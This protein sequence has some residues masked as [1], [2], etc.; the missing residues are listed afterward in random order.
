VRIEAER[1]TWETPMS[2]A[3][4]D[5]AIALRESMEGLGWEFA[6]ERSE[7]IFSRFAIIMPMPKIAYVFRFCVSEPLHDVKVDAWEMRLTHRGDITY[8]A[9]QDFR[10]E[11]LPHVRALLRELVS[12]LP[13]RPW[14]FP[15][16]QR[17]EAGLVIPEWSQSRRQWQ[18]M[19]FDVGERTPRGWVPKGSLGERMRDADPGPAGDGDAD[20]DA[21][22]DEVEV[23]APSD[24]G[25]GQRHGA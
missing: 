7:R 13:R 14:D 6:R 8:L 22:G 18:A 16:G 12:R 5:L 11:D 4:T 25:G 1:S 21:V 9:V 17:L 15:L 24:E 20:G 23:E 10:Y 3:V 2:N 19:G